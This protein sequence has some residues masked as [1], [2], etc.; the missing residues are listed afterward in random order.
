MNVKTTVPVHHT[1]TL[2]AANGSA[3]NQTR[4]RRSAV[5]HVQL[6]CMKTYLC[7]PAPMGNARKNKHV[8][9]VTLDFS[10]TAVMNVC[11]TM[12][13]GDAHAKYVHRPFA[14]TM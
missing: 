2:A 14:A 10:M 6:K 9:V 13:N 7:A 12:D 5:E 11:A 1:S 3:V 4:M 8:R